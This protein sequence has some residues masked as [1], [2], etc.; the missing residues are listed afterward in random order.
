MD[1]LGL[2]QSLPDKVEVPLRGGDPLGRFL[3]ERVEHV[4]DALEADRVDGTISV[5]V[6][7]VANLENTAANPLSGLAPRGCSPSCAAKMP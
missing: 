3:L 7:V 4:Q 6:E 1:D 2:A 5:A